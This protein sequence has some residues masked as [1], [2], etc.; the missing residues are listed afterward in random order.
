MKRGCADVEFLGIVFL[1]ILFKFRDLL[2]GFLDYFYYY[3]FVFEK[4]GFG[5]VNWVK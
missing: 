4:W 1:D 2:R 3:N 5:S